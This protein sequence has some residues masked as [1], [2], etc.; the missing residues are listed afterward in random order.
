MA[1]NMLVD[2]ISKH[3]DEFKFLNEGDEILTTVLEHHSSLVPLQEFAKKKKMKI[4]FLELEQNPSAGAPSAPLKSRGANAITQTGL[5]L[6]LNSLKNLVNE[7]TKIVSICLASNVTGGINDIKKII[8]E[9]K[10]I[11]KNVFVIC[12][13]TAAFGHIKI[14]LNK[15]DKGDNINS[16][17]NFIDAGYFSMHKAFGPTGVGVLF[18]KREI[19][20]NFSPTIFGG[21]MISH[22]EKENSE[23]RNDIKLFEAGTANISGVIGAGEAVKFLEEISIEKLEIKNR[24]LTKYAIEKLEELDFIKL[25]CAELEKNIGIISFQ[26]F[27]KNGDNFIEVHTHDVAEILARKNISVRA[28]H[29]CAE[30][31]MNYLN[32]KNGLTRISFHVYNNENDVDKLIEGLMEVK[33]VFEK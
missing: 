4:K 21:G 33:N 26:V 18:I 20:R 1:S 3:D 28:G 16:L 7:K 8:T 17:Y 25:F 29:H 23:Y 15:N 31:L 9:I 27:V 30:P 12:D 24:N 10:N 6:D 11:N 32:T 19:S 13:M 14:N 2:M 5:C 22:V